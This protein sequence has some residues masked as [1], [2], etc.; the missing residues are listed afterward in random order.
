MMRHA[1]EIIKRHSCQASTGGLN[2]V[3]HYS[4]CREEAHTFTG[5]D[6]FQY[7]WLTRSNAVM[8]YRT[9]VS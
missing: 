1:V 8:A 4:Q 5:S 9:A 3:I 2:R 7:V 6:I